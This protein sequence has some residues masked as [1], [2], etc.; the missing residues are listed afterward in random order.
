M[1]VKSSSR[2][3]DLAPL[4]TNARF[5]V[6]KATTPGNLKIAKDKSV[7]SPNVPNELILNEAF[8][9]VD[10][11][12]LFFI[13]DG[14]PYLQGIA[15][16]AAP[17]TFHVAKVDW[18]IPVKSKDDHLKALVRI[19][20]ISTKAIA[21]SR[22]GD[23]LTSLERSDEGVPNVLA[24]ATDGSEISPQIGK[25]IAAIVPTNVETD[26]SAI[27]RKVRSYDGQEGV[28]TSDQDLCKPPSYDDYM[29]YYFPELA[30][31]VVRGSTMC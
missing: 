5:F 12:I 24:T 19:D 11:V 28:D 4:L 15:R 17:S 31:P 6:A 25:D 23:V 10:N 1:L 16:I 27:H 2:A 3:K 13:L 9:R 21:F 29:K 8:A 22:I 18:E 20:W 26:F 7:W 30:V 14:L